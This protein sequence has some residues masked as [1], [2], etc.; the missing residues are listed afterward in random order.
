LRAEA[1]LKPQESYLMSITDARGLAACEMSAADLDGRGAGKDLP[2]S[3]EEE[4]KLG[5]AIMRERCI[6][7][8]E[9]LICSHSGL[10]VAIA[11]NYANRGLATTTLVKAGRT[12]L[13]HAVDHFDPAQGARFSTGASWWIKHAIREALAHAALGPVSGRN[14][15]GGHRTAPNG[16][17]D[18]VVPMSAHKNPR[19]PASTSTTSPASSAA[20]RRR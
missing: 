12:G 16:E 4:R 17:C 14:G 6:F 8:M 1:A 9:R 7:A 13:L 3:T 10:V 20:A 18:Q 2:L 5:L 11:R 19:L 15:C